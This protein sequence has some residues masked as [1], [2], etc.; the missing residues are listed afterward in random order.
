MQKHDVIEVYFEQIGGGVD[1]NLIQDE[2]EEDEDDNEENSDGYEG[3][4]DEEEEIKYVNVRVITAMN[5]H[6]IQFRIRMDTEMDIFKEIY[7]SRIG[8]PSHYL[9]F[10]FG[11]RYILNTDTPKDLDLRDN[12]IIDVYQ[13]KS[14]ETKT[15]LWNI[16][17]AFLCVITSVIAV[18]MV[19]C[20]NRK[21]MDEIL[22]E[23]TREEILQKYYQEE[24]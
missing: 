6:I 1:E 15:M 7:A 24:M 10:E 13:E 19:V 16:I 2:E 14:E 21:R 17:L 4:T 22:H 11:E 8:V 18:G 23:M 20:L 9:T 5:P 3:D 12:D